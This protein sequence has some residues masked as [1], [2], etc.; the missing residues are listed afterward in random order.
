MRKIFCL[1]NGYFDIVRI[2]LVRLV[3]GY[4][5]EY[6]VRFLG[7][8][9]VYDVQPVVH[10]VKHGGFIVLYFFRKVCHK[11]KQLLLVVEVVLLV[12]IVCHLAFSLCFQ[13]SSTGI[14]ATLY[15]LLLR[16]MT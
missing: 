4:L 12:E 10:V 2:S 9:I 1:A 3:E 11:G 15:N 7:K 16:K 14:M 8:E 6:V 5:Q 13:R